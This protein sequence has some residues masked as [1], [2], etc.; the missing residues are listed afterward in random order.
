MDNGGSSAWHALNRSTLS[1]H[2]PLLISFVYTK[3]R[4]AKISSG[5]WAAKK[6]DSIDTG[7][8]G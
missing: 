4:D 5:F 3:I 8:H 7:K 2:F 1:R 6:T